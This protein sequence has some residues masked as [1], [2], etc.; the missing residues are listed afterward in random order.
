MANPYELWDTRK[1]LGVFRDLKSSP[2]YWLDLFF[3]NSITST[4]EYIDFEKLPVAGRKLAPFVRP[5]G[6]GKPVYSDNGTGFRF[7]PAYVKVKDVIDPQMPL[8]KRPGI[9]TSILGESR[10]TA[11][12]RRELIRLAMTAQHV[13]SIQRRWEWL[14]A[15][16]IIDA[17]VTISGEEYPAVQLDFRRAANHSVTKTSGTYWG[18][19]G[20]SI[21]DD[22]Q[23]YCDRM[24]NAEF[25]AFP[26]RLTIGSKVWS[27]VRKDSEFMEHMDTT[28]RGG[29][30]TIERGVIVSDKVV[31][32]GE[33]RV[34]GGSGANIE[35]WLY[36]D[37]YEENGVEVPFM[38]ATDIVLTGT[39]ERING[40][41]CFGA[42]IDPYAQYQALPIFPR[43][44]M[45][46]DDPAVEWL[47]HQSA[48]LMVP[49]NPNATLRATV[50]AL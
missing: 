1:S 39:A 29:A 19:A 2:S 3:P 20:V 4:E 15:R 36:N 34:G 27:I 25:G 41:Q 6:T 28:Y 31:K 49:I 40:Y 11:M 23:S 50:C 22:I 46:Q 26:S 30:A 12:Q 8:V 45:T 14:A 17:A 47:L 21:F 42:I 32:V 35:I 24:F 38:S 16:A 44:Y 48:P 37:T 43:N 9:D 13:A 5:L 10:I 18:T 33:L 7:K